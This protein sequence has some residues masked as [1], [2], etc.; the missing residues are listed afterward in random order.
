[1]YTVRGS[2]VL[3]ICV[4]GKTVSRAGLRAGPVLFCLT[5]VFVIDMA[6]VSQLKR[7]EVGE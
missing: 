6:Y 4:V 7:Q 5:G 3:V 2:V 1:M